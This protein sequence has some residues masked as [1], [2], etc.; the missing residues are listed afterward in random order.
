MTNT[1]DTPEWR[2]ASD[3]FTQGEKCVWCNTTEKL[4]PNHPKRKG[5]YTHV[6]YMDL[7]NSCIIPTRELKRL[8]L[9]LIK[10]K[11][12]LCTKCN[13]MHDK[14]YLICLGCRKHYYKPKKGRDHLCWECFS[15]TTY[16]ANVK[17]YYD[18]H[19]D[20]LKKKM[21]RRTHK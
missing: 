13:F 17:D 1:W 3:A 11:F 14:G 6:E 4:A 2:A 5:G 7:E 15:K 20:E 21:N 9:P 10:T 16:G 19:P 12:I 18:K 8:S